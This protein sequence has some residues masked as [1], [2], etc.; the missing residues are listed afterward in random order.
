MS[1]C[2]VVAR[3]AYCAT[4]SIG[5]GHV[6]RFISSTRCPRQHSGGPARTPTPAV[7]VCACARCVRVCWSNVVRVCGDGAGRHLEQGGDAGVGV[8]GGEGPG[9]PGGLVAEV[10]GAEADEDEES[11]GGGCDGCCGCGAGEGGRL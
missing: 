10:A 6:V 5:C 1:N 3:G 2:R 11:L 8:E 7:H 9:G 4:A